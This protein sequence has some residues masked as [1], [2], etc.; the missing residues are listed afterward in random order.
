ML[1]VDTVIQSLSKLISHEHSGFPLQFTL[2]STRVH[3]VFTLCS[4]CVQLIFPIP[5]SHT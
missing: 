4:S 1:H 2:C 3:L 5:C